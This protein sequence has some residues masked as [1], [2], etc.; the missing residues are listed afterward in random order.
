MPTGKQTSGMLTGLSFTLGYI[1][2][3]KGI[4]IEPCAANMPEYW[5]MDISLEGAVVIG[6]VLKFIVAAIVA[7]N[8]ADPANDGRHPGTQLAS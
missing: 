1:I 3:F 4:F 5:I 7:C 2:Y 6:M 8:S